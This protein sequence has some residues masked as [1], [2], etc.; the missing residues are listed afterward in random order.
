MSNLT[1][2]RPATTRRAAKCLTGRPV[3]GLDFPNVGLRPVADIAVCDRVVLNPTMPTTV[4]RSVHHHGKRHRFAVTP[5][6]ESSAAFKAALVELD[7]Q[8]RA[9]TEAKAKDVG[10]KSYRKPKGG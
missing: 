2:D 10:R 1:R 7:E 5:K 4:S 8:V 9:F 3:S 6:D